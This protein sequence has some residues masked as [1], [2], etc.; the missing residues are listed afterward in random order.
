M[1]VTW[2]AASSACCHDFSVV[3]DWNSNCKAELTVP[4]WSCF[5]QAFCC[6]RTLTNI[7]SL[8][9]PLLTQ[10]MATAIFLLGGLR[11]WLLILLCLIDKL[12]TA[13][14]SRECDA[15]SLSHRILGSYIFVS[16]SA[17]SSSRISSCFFYEAR[18][19][20][21]CQCKASD[22]LIS[23]VFRL[24]ISNRRREKQ[25]NCWSDSKVVLPGLHTVWGGGESW[26]C[27]LPWS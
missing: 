11:A 9:L 22:R 4:S 19:P 7:T 27:R 14:K 23:A 17:S 3:M 13:S 12:H 15:F 5:G 18:T 20:D 25:P 16:I 10:W 21:F 26:N 24:A 8:S 2:P 1:A 6:Y